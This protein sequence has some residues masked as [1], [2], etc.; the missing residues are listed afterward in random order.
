[1]LTVTVQSQMAEAT[2]QMMR[3]CVL[4]ATR[5][6]TESALRGLS[7]W[8]EMMPATGERTAG[9]Q[10]YVANYRYS[11]GHAAAQVIVPDRDAPRGLAPMYGVLDAWRAAFGA[12]QQ[13]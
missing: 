8:S 9:S 12:G 10:G 5:P 6:W 4:A 13:N 1:M 11:G 2:A 3:A 7:L